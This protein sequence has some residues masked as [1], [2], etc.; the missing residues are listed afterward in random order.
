[1]KKVS[2]LVIAD[3]AVHSRGGIVNKKSPFL[4]FVHRSA[5]IMLCVPMQNLREHADLST[6]QE[7]WSNDGQHRA[8]QIANTEAAP[9][10][11][12]AGVESTIGIIVPLSVSSVLTAPISW[13]S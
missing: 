2:R 3:T 4:S 12:N 7:S 1:M 9:S 8:C 13:A 11:Q 10:H 5:N 6:Q